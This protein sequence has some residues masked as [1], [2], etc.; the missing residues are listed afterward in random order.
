M[1]CEAPTATGVP[2]ARW[3]IAELQREAI[4]RGLVATIGGTTLWRWLQRDAI[5]PWCHR[6][7]LFPRDPN[8][9]AKA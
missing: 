7:W 8:F 9:R 1:A 2:L 4:E 6:S 5:R 3:S